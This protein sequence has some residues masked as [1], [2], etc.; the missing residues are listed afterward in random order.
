MVLCY[1]YCGLDSRMKVRHLE[2]RLSGSILGER[3]ALCFGRVVAEELQLHY[4][5]CRFR[6]S[7]HRKAHER[8]A[9]LLE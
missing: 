7:N 3:A 1:A 6:V 8:R 4:V 5:F 2:L 9:E